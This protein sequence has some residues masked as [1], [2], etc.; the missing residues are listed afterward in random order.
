MSLRIALFGQAAFGRETLERLS[1]NGHEIV[2][3]FAPPDAG[4]PDPLATRAQELGLPLVRR[5]FYRKK[6]GEAIPAALAEHAALGA[7]L[8]VLASVQVFLPRELTDA[9]KHKSLCFH[10][11]L[12]PR[13]RGGAALQW[14]IILGEPETGV[15]IFVPD[16]GADTGPI[17]LQKGPV[18]IGP[19]ET[20]TSLFFEKLQP[21]G[22]EALVE[23]VEQ[24]ASG[25][26][27]PRAQDE[28]RASFQGLVDDAVAAVDLRK[29]AV[30]IDRLV[31]GCDPQPG[32]FLR[33]E[34]KPVR[35]FDAELLPALDLTPGSVVRCDAAGLVVAL[36][37]GA[38]RVGRVRADQAKEPAQAFAE[39]AGLGAGGRLESGA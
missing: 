37:G 30:E 35:L 32:A 11:S 36:R 4:R 5:R 8:N 33:L 21:L 22:V 15:S 28:A 1:A 27:R 29:S 10:P 19:R 3:V 2:G 26:A 34:G 13:F 18:P 31:R 38:L 6:T 12:L 14:Q 20:V 7:E 24:V 9:P 23:A 17:V 39:R 25:R 16:E